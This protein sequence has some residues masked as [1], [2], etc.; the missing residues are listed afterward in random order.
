[1]LR[2]ALVGS[3][4]HCGVQSSS[5]PVL[6]RRDDANSISQVI[7]RHRRPEMKLQ[8]Q[9]APGA[10][11]DNVSRYLDHIRLRFALINVPA[12]ST[13]PP[14]GAEAGAVRNLVDRRD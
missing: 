3:D 9:L 5:K 13:R 2:F 7:K 12:G 1:M 6:L 11:Q 4:Q 14:A 8:R 10:M